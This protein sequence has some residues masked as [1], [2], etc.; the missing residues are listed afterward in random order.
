MT[1]KT[2][3]PKHRRR[4]GV[5][6]NAIIVGLCTAMA[7]PIIVQGQVVIYE[8]RRF[9][10]ESEAFLQRDR[11]A[12]GS[13]PPEPAEVFAL[14]TSAEPERAINERYAGIT[15]TDDEYWEL[16]AVISLE[17]ADQCAKGQQAVAEVILN[18]VISPDFPD[19]VHG[20]LHQQ[21]PVQFTTAELISTA[22]PTET[23]KT[24]LEAALYG[25][26][27]LPAGVVFFSQ[28]GE[29]DRVYATIQDHVFCCGY[30]W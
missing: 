19:T 29:N 20:V 26:S 5:N 21:N 28:N 7:I 3:K 15:I 8:S 11:P 17:A 14:D 25:E 12:D 23:Q 1:H 18:W 2:E 13:I 9:L 16:L 6:Y 27:V 22:I 30:E 10:A 24:A 4:K